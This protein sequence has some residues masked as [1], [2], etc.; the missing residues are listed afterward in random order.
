MAEGNTRVVVGGG[1]HFTH[2]TA[3]SISF[4]SVTDIIKMAVFEKCL[5]AVLQTCSVWIFHAVFSS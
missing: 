2:S 3:V 5:R 1:A 4:T